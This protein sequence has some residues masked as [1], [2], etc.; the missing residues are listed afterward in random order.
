M[1]RVAL[2]SDANDSRIWSTTVCPTPHSS[3]IALLSARFAG[4]CLPSWPIRVDVTDSVT[5]D[6]LAALTVSLWTPQRF[7]SCEPVRRG[8][9]SIGVFRQCLAW[10]HG[11][12]AHHRQ[13]QRSPDRWHPGR[14]RYD[15][16]RLRWHPMPPGPASRDPPSTVRIG[17]L[18][19]RAGGEIPQLPARPVDGRKYA[20]RWQ[21]C[22][23]IA[24]FR[25]TP[26]PVG[27]LP[28]TRCPRLALSV[29][30]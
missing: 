30:D 7:A 12:H 25:D 6:G 5:W 4:Y 27:R 1:V 18:P 26:I 8:T 11:F 16:Q 10:S 3:L 13:R 19:A 20:A 29:Q 28:R 24:G 9:G 2:A 22:I 21:I 15:A 14:L 23:S 17:H